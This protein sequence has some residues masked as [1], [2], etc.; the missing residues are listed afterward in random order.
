MPIVE[1]PPVESADEQ[2]LLAVGGDLHMDSLLLAYSK[3]IY[4][5]PITPNYP[6]AWFSPD[7]RGVIP[8]NDFHVP[9]KLKKELKDSKFHIR[10]NQKFEKVITECAQIKRKKE[11]GTWITDEIIVGYI[12]FFRAGYAY[13]VEVYNEDDNLVGGLYGVKIGKFFSGESMYH[14]ESNASKYALLTLMQNLK[15]NGVDFLDTQMVTTAT[16]SLG[17]IEIP[18]EIYVNKIQKLLAE[19]T[20]DIEK[21]FSTTLDLTCL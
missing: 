2:G 5:W 16:K 13:S 19:K 14:R 6:M 15:R 4:P 9:R 10:Y 1:F 18:R 21:E 7:P 3:G 11:F 20:I 17:A 12:N 8:S